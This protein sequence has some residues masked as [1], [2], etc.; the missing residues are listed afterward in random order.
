MREVER[1][2]Q[3][4]IWEKIRLLESGAESRSLE[5]SEKSFTLYLPPWSKTATMLIQQLGFKVYQ[6]THTHTYIQK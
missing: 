2:D 1:E 6:Y 4:V 5:Y 3:L